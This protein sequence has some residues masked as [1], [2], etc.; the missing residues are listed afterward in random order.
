MATP[1]VSLKLPPPN[2]DHS[3]DDHMKMS[4][5]FIRLAR[6]ELGQG[7]RLQASEKAWG[8]LAQAAKA[9]GVQRGWK[10]RSHGLMYAIVSQVG[11]EHGRLDFVDQFNAVESHHRNFYNND[12]DA[13]DIRRTID[14]VEKLVEDLDRVR[15][16]DGLPYKVSTP[17]AQER[18]HKLTGKRPRIGEE[19]PN[20]FVVER[21]RWRDNGNQRTASNIQQRPGNPTNGAGAAGRGTKPG[22]RRRSRNKKGNGKPRE[23]N[24]RLG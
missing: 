4:R 1:K 11:N 3:P 12:K 24:I 17:E 13:D 22:R 19:S 6:I 16:S 9:I 5:R 8:G 23:V 10:H 21:F 14:N 20:G 18:L 7:R 2:D 15:Q